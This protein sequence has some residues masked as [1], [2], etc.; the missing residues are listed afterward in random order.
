MITYNSETKIF[1]L[2]TKETSYIMGIAAGEHLAHLYWGKRVSNIP[3]QNDIYMLPVIGSHS[4]NVL[5]K[6]N[7]KDGRLSLEYL[8]QEYP[9]FNTDLRTPSVH[10]KYSDGTTYSRFTYKSHE[11]LKGKPSI[12]GLPSIYTEDKDEA[13]TL[14]ITLFDE[15]KKVELILSYSVLSDFDVITRSV[16]VVNKGNDDI[17][18]LKAM[19]ASVD[20]NFA[21]FDMTDLYGAWARE[22]RINKTPLK[23]GTSKIE[24]MRGSSSHNE[25]PFFA[26]STK[27]ANE[28]YGE[29]YGFS[30]VYSG[31][32]E[33]G[34]YVSTYKETRASIGINSFDFS[35]NLAS[36]EEFNTPEAVLVYSAEGFGKMSRTY[37][38]VYRERLCRGKFRD[39][40]RP[41]LINNWE[42]TYFNFDEEKILN[43][44]KKA[45][46]ADIELFVLDDGWFGKRNMDD[47]SLGDW[48]V[49]SE[50][51]PS[52]IDGLAKKINEIGMKF[53]LWFEPEMVSVDSD[54]Y[55]AHPDWCLHINKRERNEGRN[56]LVLDLSRKEVVDYLENAISDVLSSANIEYV[57]W[58]M[59]RS[60]SEVGNE[61]LEG[62]YQKEIYHRYILG[63]YDLLERLTTK[64]P[65]VLFEGCAG[66]GG[67]FDPGMLYY[68]PQIWKSDD[69]DAIERL[70][71]QEGTALCY[72][73]SGMGAHVSAVPNHQVKRMTKIDTRGAVAMVG[74]FGYELNLLA[75][76]DEEMEKIKGQVAL[77][78]EIASDIKSAEYYKLKSV[79][80]DEFSAWEFLSEDKERAYLMLCN[81]IAHANANYE[82][83]RFKNLEPN[84]EYKERFTN[85][86]YFGEYLMNVGLPY[87]RDLDFSGKILI[88]EKQ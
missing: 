77:Y 9:A 21:D 26:L 4:M 42:A 81:T 11:I 69:S 22:R 52:G 46:E 87:K 57:K 55:R 37:H 33:A 17:T 34:A 76:S 61:V 53:G 49:F 10:I 64:F 78:K 50:K 63:L 19:S 38:K 47:S 45:K 65:D 80:E 85:K 60:M 66:G 75:L 74:A 72:P 15:V 20:F 6:K 13:E 14:L 44:A 51:L 23:I 30:L 43:I 70:Y 88:F 73:F 59:N 41:I 3:S 83:I 8:P 2:S 18:I 54:L 24:S 62:K 82:F 56:Q 29:V 58:D 28:E 68:F 35:Y 5:E 31:N 79:Y 32:F 48:K 7:I 27:G 40:V 16:K 86:T 1:H 36:G 71:I 39:K 12:S 84:A 67:R 25:N